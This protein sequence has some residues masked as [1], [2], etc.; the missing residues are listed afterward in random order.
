MDGRGYDRWTQT[1]GIAPSRRTLLGGIAG[2]AL[3]GLLG[4]RAGRAGAAPATPAAPRKQ[5]RLA[6][7]SVLQAGL[8]WVTSRQDKS[9]GFPSARGGGDPVTTAETVGV[10]IALRNVGI[11]VETDTALA[12]LR[13]T[14]PTALEGRAGGIPEVVMAL[15]AAGGDPRAVRG[16]DLVARV[17]ATWDAKAGLY[18]TATGASSGL[19]TIENALALMA[20]SAVGAPI[21]PQA[22]ATIAA[23]QTADG[24]WAAGGGTGSGDAVT[25]AFVI[26]A[27]AAVGHRDEKIFADAVAYLRT[28][29]A[30][31]TAA[32]GAG[33]FRPNPGA[34]PD[35]NTTGLVISALT[36]AG[37][38][39]KAKKWGKA[40][41]GLLA[42]QNASGAFRYNDQ[43]PDDDLVSTISALIALA[44]ASLPVLPT[45]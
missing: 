23:T 21:E 12:Y 1:T 10:L 25:T 17:A 24:S 3:G 35:A 40:V 31:D 33:A 5:K 44:G 2:A 20:L 9:G 7:A 13:Q 28:V 43:E 34:P 26:Q 41:S 8:A 4:T 42:F 39:P 16:I 38:N 6:K 29:Q 30:G 11:A 14:D 19:G 37:E 18:E 45:T 15:V 22:V 27:L 32:F 36:A